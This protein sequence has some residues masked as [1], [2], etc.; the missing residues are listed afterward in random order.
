M[1]E[2][3]PSVPA[4]PQAPARPAQ[5]VAIRNCRQ[6]HEALFGQEVH[7][8][9]EMCVKACRRSIQALHDVLLQQSIR[10]A[11]VL[12]DADA[13]RGCLWDAAHQAGGT[14]LVKARGKLAGEAVLDHKPSP[15]DPTS[16][17]LT[18]SIKT[19]QKPS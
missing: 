8:N 6:C 14:L 4:L 9:S 18:A 16:V 13:M 5:Q 10:H 7:L 19:E 11:R 1:P 17:V 15:E 3:N 2:L 12:R